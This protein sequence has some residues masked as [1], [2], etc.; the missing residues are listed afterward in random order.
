M[1]KIFNAM[2]DLVLP[3]V[4][5]LAV[6][7]ILTGVSLFYKIGK[8]I[9]VKEEDFSQMQDRSIMQMLCERE[10]PTIRCVGKKLWNIGEILT[11]S[12]VFAAED[13]EAGQV[14]VSVLDITNQDGDSVMEC[15]RK[16]LGQVIFL[17]RGVYTFSLAAMDGQR[18]TGTEEISIIVDAR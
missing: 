7:A 8:R 11:V 4:V 10:A 2:S 14:E 5:F 12:A 16:D 3:A 17:Q 18:K 13:A 15:Y 6:A 1:K 9:E